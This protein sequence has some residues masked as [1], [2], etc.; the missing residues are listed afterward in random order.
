MKSDVKDRGVVFT[1]EHIVKFMTS[2]IDNTLS[3]TIL[4]PSCGM[5]NIVEQI[6]K[7]HKIT[8]I[9]INKQYIRHCAKQFS[10][11]K[12]VTKNF[13]HY[14]TKEKF[15]YIIGNP[16]YVKIQ[17]ITPKDMTEI[18]KEYPTFMKGNTNLYIYFIL[19]CF[20]LLKDDGKLIFIV[21]NTWLYNSS[22]QRLKNWIISNKYL[23]VL[24]DFKGKQIFD[25]V[26]TYTC[27][28]ILS[29]KN[30]F[31][32]YSNSIDNKL[33]KKSYQKTLTDKS[34]S[35]S[36]SLLDIM[37]PRIGIMTLKDDVFIIKKFTVK[38]NKV[39]FSKDNKDF[40]IERDACKK[41][42]KVSKNQIYL[43]IYPYDA[44]AKIISDLKKKFP[45]TFNYLS[46]Y[47][48]QLLDRENGNNNYKYWYEYG[49]TQALKI[50]KGKRLFISTIVKNIRDFVYEKDVELY[51]SGMWIQPKEKHSFSY[52][53]N[54]LIEHE[55]QILSSSNNKSSNWYGL[56]KNSFVIYR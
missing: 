13:I 39:Y 28:M 38:D 40:V 22:L 1:P 43:I 32:H 15:D 27:I 3:H 4:E 23:E 16:P 7:K 19:K 26:S 12:C 5:G 10:N 36:S 34:N 9:D 24:I 31:Y 17:N 21:P 2:Y 45:L 25:N 54:K 20:N 47:K 35:A 42:L 46:K 53:K 55:Q 48:Q 18:R 44:N 14:K 37:T 11:A 33:V 51:Y 29:K 41:I 49:R 8:C 30:Q 56:S 52:I 50:V 6:D